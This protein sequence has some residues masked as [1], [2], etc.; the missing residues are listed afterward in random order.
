MKERPVSPVDLGHYFKSHI[1]LA[2]QV[3]SSADN[4]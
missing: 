2:L 1:N 4:T 3:G